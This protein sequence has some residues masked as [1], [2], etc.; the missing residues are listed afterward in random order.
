MKKIKALSLTKMRHFCFLLAA[1]ILSVGLFAQVGPPN[2]GTPLAG[3]TA[4]T[5]AQSS[6]TYTAITGGTQYQAGATMNTDAVSAAVNIGFDFRYNNRMYSTVRISNNGFITFGANAPLTTTYTGLSTNVN[7]A[8][9]GAIAG[10]AANLRASAVAGA[11][12]EIRYET[13]GAS[14][15]RMFVVQYQDVAILTTGVIQRLNFQI[16]LNETTNTV[17]IVYGTVASGASASTGQVGLKGGESSDVSNRTGTNWT[18]TNPGTAITSTCTIGTTNGTT[19]PASGLTFTWTPGTTW[20]ATSYATLPYLNDFTTWTNALNT[21]DSPGS[22]VRTWPSRGDNSWRSSGT[23]VS[24]FTSTISW[25]SILG[26]TA[27]YSGAAIAPGARFHSYDVSAGSFGDIDFYL[28]MSSSPIGVYNVQFLY[29]N[30][31]GTD[32]IQ[33]FYSGDAGTTFTQ[34]G[35]NITTGGNVWNTFSRN[36]AG[37]ATA[38]IRIRAIGDFGNDDINIDNF[39]VTALTCVSPSALLYTPSSATGGTLSWTNQ[40]S[41]TPTNYEYE[42]RTSGAAGS[43]ATGLVNSGTVAHPANSAAISVGTLSANTAYSVYIRT[44]CGGGDLSGWSSATNF[45]T[46]CSLSVAPFSQTFAAAY[47][48]APTGNPSCWREATGAINLSGN[49]TVTAGNNNWG[50]SN[51]ANVAGNTGFKINMYGNNNAWVITEPITLSAGNWSLAYSMAVTTVNATGSVSDMGTHAL[52]VIVSTDFGTTWSSANIIK[53]YTG[54]GSYSNTGVAEYVSLNAYAGQTVQIGFVAST[55]TTAFDYEFHLDNIAVI[56]PCSGIPVIGASAAASPTNIGCSGSVVSLTMDA[57]AQVGPGVSYQWASSADGITFTNISGAVSSTYSTPETVVSSTYYRGTA[58]CSFSGLSN[59][60]ADYFVEAIFPIPTISM[61]PPQFCGEGGTSA[62]TAN[63]SGTNPY[64]AFFWYSPET[65]ILTNQTN[66]TTDFTV[67]QTAALTF[68]AIDT[69][70]G[71]AKTVSQALNVLNGVIPDMTATPA[72]V[73]SGGS[74]TLNSGLSSVNFASLSISHD[75]IPANSTLVNAGQLLSPLTSGNLD[76]GGWGNIPIGFSFNFFGTL[77]SS[78]NIGTN[79]T[80]T[81]GAYNSSALTDYTFI[82]L[83]N[84]LEPNP[85]IAV[86]A[87]DHDPTGTLGGSISYSTFGY[88]RNR[89]FV[90]SYKNVK[91]FGDTKYSTATLHLYEATGEIEIHVTSSTNEDRVKLVGVN[92]PGGTIGTLAYNSGTTA[93]DVNPISSPLAYRFIPPQNYTTVWTPSFN[94]NGPASGTNLF[95]R[96]TTELSNPG[97]N[98]FNLQLTNQQTGCASSAQVSVIV[99]QPGDSCDDNDPCTEVDLI[100]FDCSCAGTFS[101]ADNDGTCDAFDGCYGPEAGTTCDDF[102][103]CTL[104]DLIQNDCSCEGTFTDG[105][106]DGTCDAN[107]LCAGPETGSACDD[108][109]QC[110]VNDFIQ[111]DCTCVGIFV[112]TDNDGICD[113]EDTCNGPANAICGCTDGTACNYDPNANND[114]GSCEYITCEGCTDINACNYDSNAKI[115]APVECCYDNCITL[116]M[117]D[118]FGDGWN[119]ASASILDQSGSIVATISLESGS[120]SSYSL[121]LINGCFTIIVGGGNFDGEISWT[122]TGVQGGNLNGLANDPSGQIFRTSNTYCNDNNACTVNDFI[123]SDCTCA[124][125]FADTDNDGTCD[126]NDLC[127]GP[128]AGT[129]CDDNDPCTGNDVIQSD[130]TCEGTFDDADN[131]GTCNANDNCAGPEVGTACDDN[132]PCTVN[133]LVQ[134]DC[135]CVGTFADADNDGTCD[136][137]DNCVGVEVGSEC[138][139]GNPCTLNDVIRIDCSCLG[140]EDV[141]P[142]TFAGAFSDTIIRVNPGLPLIQMPDGTGTGVWNTVNPDGVVTGG[143]VCS[144]EVC[145]FNGWAGNVWMG[146]TLIWNPIGA[147]SGGRYYTNGFYVSPSGYYILPEGASEQGLTYTECYLNTVIQPPVANDNTDANAQVIYLGESIAPGDCEYIE[148]VRTK[149]W[150]AIDACGNVSDT[151]YKSQI[152]LTEINGPNFILYDYLVE[153]NFIDTVSCDETIEIQSPVMDSLAIGQTQCSQYTIAIVSDTTFIDY[154]WEYSVD[155][156][157]RE[158]T[159]SIAA[160]CGPSWLWTK[161]YIIIDTIAPEIILPGNDTIIN[162]PNTPVFT[163]PTLSYENCGEAFIYQFDDYFDTLDC[164]GSYNQTR[165]W[166][167]YDESYNFTEEVSQTITVLITAC[168]DND[169]CT[170]N[171][172]IQSDCSCAGTFA[173][174]DNDGTCD[175]NDLCAGP[176]TGTACDDADACTINDIIQ[177]DCT[178]AGTFATTTA[179]ATR[180]ISVRVRRRALLV[181]TTMLAPSMM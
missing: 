99:V 168:D 49:S 65:G 111:S 172:L 63:I 48:L 166:I 52:R 29:N 54:A 36:I 53:T 76:D 78:C 81:F 59:T 140:E 2:S 45:T 14:P 71:C 114:N 137:N 163:P 133:D 175:A 66:F 124:G 88:P 139:D 158:I 15:N 83:P 136:A 181:M 116:L 106:N 41:G 75:P 97:L 149:A 108:N 87:M 7:P 3:T 98:L 38:V 109:N 112:D 43:G 70:S 130:C 95:S 127:A 103:P 110:T 62:V 104:N 131:D 143:I 27:T 84:I 167:A 18:S 47:S 69:T 152:V 101:D 40:S 6:G 35:S 115:S 72:V 119:G 51:F 39:R 55:A 32:V 19:V 161:T 147:S 180:T 126:A 153:N 135:T 22:S 179:P 5:F 144:P 11:T 123:Q 20:S 142:P 46:P 33:V 145:G 37:T 170:V 141:T 56:V 129:A 21:G 159:W 146:D 61:F 13:L 91:E 67:N 10:F 50:S 57:G 100:Q 82:T 164:S 94:I 178:C 23:L 102:D 138:D 89:V 118:T 1:Q 173:D 28:D 150:I 79:G 148:F 30:P 156:E 16:R 165:T 44:D 31:S 132:D 125:T 113:G 134:S 128:E 12:P 86:L 74:T 64:N 122:L 26:Q 160:G 85:M 162:Y 117:Y 107:D 155:F 176:E 96:V 177:S 151:V 73:C 4:Y 174:G 93:S 17:S 154:S 90:V 8:C 121:C 34:V 105:D 25:S 77:Y 171:D 157:R 92:G 169:P 80:V 68:T 24:G 60:T 58:T 9:E 120:F 42:I